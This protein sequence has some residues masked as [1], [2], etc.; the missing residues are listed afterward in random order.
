M[1]HRHVCRQ[2]L[3]FLGSYNAYGINSILF[4][5]YWNTGSPQDQKRWFDNIVVSTKRVGCA[6]SVPGAVGLSP[7]K[8][9]EPGFTAAA[10]GGSW[11]VEGRALP[12]DASVP[13]PVFLLGEGTTRR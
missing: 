5:N 7:R 4:E 8:A 1:K 13:L 10:R 12:A 9:P 6:E 3:D 2:G 11:T